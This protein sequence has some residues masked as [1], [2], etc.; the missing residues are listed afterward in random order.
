M[1]F[2][3]IEVTGSHLYMKDLVLGLNKD[4]DFNQYICI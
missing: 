3:T 4:K 1:T 2:C